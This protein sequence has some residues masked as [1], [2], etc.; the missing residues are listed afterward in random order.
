M[1]RWSSKIR[2]IIFK[3]KIFESNN[4]LQEKDY[5]LKEKEVNIK[6]KSMDAETKRVILK[7]LIEQGKSAQECK[8]YLDAMGL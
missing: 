3:N 7:S 8:D 4:S 1:R 6:E 2:L 5:L